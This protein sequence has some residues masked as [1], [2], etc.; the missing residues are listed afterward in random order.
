MIGMLVPVWVVPG[1]AAVREIRVA[2]FNTM[3]FRSEAG[4]LVDELG[5][6]SQLD[7]RRVAEII[8]RVDPH[9]IL[10]N[11]FDYDAAHEALQRLQSNFLGVGQNGQAPI[12]F[13]YRFAAESNTGIASCF[14]LNNDGRAAKA[15]GEFG[16]ADD[17]FGFGQFPGQYGMVVLSKFPI[18]L[19]EVR[20]FQKFLW[21]DMP[22]ALLPDISVTPAVADWY[23]AAELEVVRLSSK[24]HWDLPIDV[25]GEVVHLLAAHPTPPTFDG[26]ENRNGLRNHDEIRLWADYVTPGGAEY[27]YD[28]EGVTGGIGEDVRFVICGDYNA[29]PVDGD[30]V[31]RAI[32]QLLENPAVDAAVTPQGA[33]GTTD[34]STFG[35]RV[36]YVLPSLAGFDPQAGAI[37]WPTGGQDGADLVGASDHRLVWMDLELTPLISE[38]VRGLRIGIEAADVVLRWDAVAGIDY[39]VESSADLEG[40]APVGG[41]VEVSEGGAT[42]RDVDGAARGGRKYYRVSARFVEE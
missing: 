3:L 41:G 28:D 35:L 40:W 9:I 8:Q 7:P 21:R 12:V 10:L 13:P 15:L 34:T 37:F 33:S 36:D 1:I 42:F 27:L 25:D 11:E 26:S 18:R 30:S 39:G 20:T 32:N 16:Y 6:P 5:T 14:D 19:D 31:D 2:T 29:D 22:G 17:S 38:A 4:M 23:S 24:S